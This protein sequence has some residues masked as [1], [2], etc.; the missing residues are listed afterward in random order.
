MSYPDE[1]T[2]AAGLILV[3]NC[4]SGSEG[5]MHVLY[6]ISALL[7]KL[8]GSK[9]LSRSLVT[10]GERVCVVMLD[11]LATHVNAPDTRASA[12]EVFELG[13]V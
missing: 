4:V 13:Y 6:L 1:K 7:M 5:R 3:N 8:I 12:D 10:L 2:V 9:N 11:L